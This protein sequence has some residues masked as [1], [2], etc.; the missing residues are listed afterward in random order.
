MKTNKIEW[1]FLFRSSLNAPFVVNIFAR[2]HLD[3]FWGNE[4]TD[5]SQAYAKCHVHIYIT[6]SNTWIAIG[7]PTATFKSQRCQH[8]QQCHASTT[9]LIEVGDSVEQHWS[10]DEKQY[11]RGFNDAGIQFCLRLGTWNFDSKSWTWNSC[12]R[13]Y[14]LKLKS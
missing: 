7:T 2:N 1:L 5:D 8:P 10:S 4:N 13:C 9:L 3:R 12:L 14:W 6:L 11:I